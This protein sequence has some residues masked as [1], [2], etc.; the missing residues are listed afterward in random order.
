VA[1]IFQEVDEEVRRERLEQLWKRYGNYVIAAAFV[2]LAAIGGWRGY[3]YWEQR[4]AAEA[5][6]AFEVASVLADEG[7]H[8]EAQAAFAKLATEG[9]KGYRVLAR[10]REAGQLALSDPKAAVG[11]YDALAADASLGQPLQD[12]ATVRAASLLVDS[13]PYEEL[14]ARLEPLSAVDRPFRHSARELLAL[15]A[16]RAG[17]SAAARRW[18]DTVVSDPETPPSIRSRVDVLMAL[19]GSDGK[20]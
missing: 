11:A 14:R 3:V 18:I 12:L 10:F 6:A 1:D 9:T 19:T 2:V 4:K 15:S 8:A 17:D 7:K 16:W 5:G 13:A 20:G